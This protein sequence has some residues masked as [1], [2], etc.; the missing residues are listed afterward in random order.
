[1]GFFAWKNNPPNPK[2]KQTVTS[3]SGNLDFALPKNQIKNVVGLLSPIII[4][5]FVSSTGSVQRTMV[6]SRE[7]HG[8]GMALL[9]QGT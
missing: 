7:N 3:W 8:K 5:P 4:S 9:T 6:T 2:R 1:V